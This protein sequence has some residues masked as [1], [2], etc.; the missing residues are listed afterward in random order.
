M[1]DDDGGGKV[2]WTWRAKRIIAIVRRRTTKTIWFGLGGSLFGAYILCQQIVT[3]RNRFTHILP[4]GVLDISKKGPSYIYVDARTT[5]D[6]H[7]EV[8]REAMLFS[9]LQVSSQ[10]HTVQKDIPL[11][12]DP[13]KAGITIDFWELLHNAKSPMLETRVRGIKKLAELTDRLHISSCTQ[14]AQASDYMTAIGLARSKLYNLD[15]LL[16]PPSLPECKEPEIE[17]KF[18]TVLASLPETEVIDCV[19][20][21][22]KHAMDRGHF[23]S[24][25][26]TGG[27]WY[28]GSETGMKGK[29]LQRISEDTMKLF[30]LE[31]LYSHSTVPSHRKLIVDNG[32]LL[33]M[34][35]MYLT[36]QSKLEVQSLIAQILGN[37]ALDE[38]LHYDIFHSGWVRLLAKMMRSNTVELSLPAGR[39]LA[40]MDRDTVNEKYDEGVSLLYPMYRHHDT[41]LT[42]DVVFVH[43]ISGGVFKTWR[44]RDISSLLATTPV[45]ESTASNMIPEGEEKGLERRRD[46]QTA[47]EDMTMK[48]FKRQFPGEKHQP[49]PDHERRFQDWIKLLHKKGDFPRHTQ[50]WPKDWLPKD[51][52]MIRVVGVDFDA[53]MSEWFR[54]CPVPP[55]KRSLSS[56][57]NDMLDRLLKAHIG[58]RPIIWVTHSMGGLLVKKLLVTAYNSTDPVIHRVWDNTKGV[59][60]FSVP[61]RGSLWSN[62]GGMEF[63]MLPTAEVQ[64]L[65]YNSPQLLELHVQFTELAEK[66]HLPCLSFGETLKTGLG[67]KL[68]AL[69]VSPYSS[70]PGFGIYYTVG[71]DHINVCKPVHRRSKLYLQVVEFIFEHIP[72]TI[73]DSL[74]APTFT[75]LNLDSFMEDY[76]MW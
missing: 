9:D 4:H 40:N 27:D 44:Q 53:Q 60:F 69:F 3:L 62:W 26:E 18:R 67:Y 38:T 49:N 45:D 1:P 20:Y 7:E 17:R 8:P 58:K 61:H 74:M 13:D 72:H 19:A 54:K 10:W 68:E 56:R 39:A 5:E 43:G 23:Y 59:I 21:I 51:C 29:S 16:K 2:K 41:E 25:A 55:E 15:C 14:I 71:T 35:Q 31:A 42:A 52:P 36:C 70:D 48:S 47:V 50:C 30:Y 65:K 73:L 22:T 33:L 24:A 75:K 32:A 34:L 37:L 76:Y 12:W 57:S 66:V 64:E 28:F 46:I 63:F 6:D 11:I